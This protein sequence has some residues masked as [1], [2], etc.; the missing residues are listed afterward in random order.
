MGYAIQTDRRIEADQTT[1][2]LMASKIKVS[3]IAD[4][5]VPM[6]Y[7]IRKKIQ[8]KDLRYKE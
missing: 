8:E 2:S 4:I 5:S 3:L 6:D 1:L 7:G